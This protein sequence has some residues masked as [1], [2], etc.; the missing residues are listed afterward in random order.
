MNIG[1]IST[2]IQSPCTQ[3]QLQTQGN[4]NINLRKIFA[5]QLIIKGK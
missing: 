3:T 2:I 5:R 1:R 4:K